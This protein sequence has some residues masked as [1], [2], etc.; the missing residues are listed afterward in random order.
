MNG[1]HLYMRTCGGS[2]GTACRS[3]QARDAPAHAHKLRPPRNG[4]CCTSGP[5]VVRPTAVNNLHAGQRPIPAGTRNHTPPCLSAW[6]HSLLRPPPSF[7]ESV[8]V[9]SNGQ[10]ISSNNI[11]LLMERRIRASPS[12]GAGPTPSQSTPSS[13]GSLYAVNIASWRGRPC[14]LPLSLEHVQP[15]TARAG[16]RLACTAVYPWPTHPQRPRL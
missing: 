13:H 11:N 12:P 7:C 5:Y 1:V 15:E 14:A 2:P 10:P 16:T 3:R 9:S 6:P 4:K 8:G